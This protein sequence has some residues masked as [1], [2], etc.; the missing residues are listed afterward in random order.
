MEIDEPVEPVESKCAICHDD[1]VGNEQDEKAVRTLPCNHQFHS[2]CINKWIEMRNLCPLCR[3]VADASQPV[4]ELDSDN[5]ELTHM[6][7]E[8]INSSFGFDDFISLFGSSSSRPRTLF[9]RRVQSPIDVRSLFS[10]GRRAQPI[11]NLQQ[12]NV[13]HTPHGTIMSVGIEVK[14]PESGSFQPLRLRSNPFPPQA[15]QQTDPF[16]IRRLLSSSLP[17]LLASSTTPTRTLL[18]EFG[19]RCTTPSADCVGM[20]CAN[21]LRILCVHDIKRCTGCRNIRYCGPEC[22]RRHWDAHRDD[23]LRA[24]ASCLGSERMG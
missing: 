5:A 12:T 8:S 7:L 11:F 16:S 2:E 6:F 4:R 1:L 14:V 9:S 19:Y 18:N 13:R 21:C 17:P 3:Q 23:C 10:P 15:T 22:Q 20:Q 24:R